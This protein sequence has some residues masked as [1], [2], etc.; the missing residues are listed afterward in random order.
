MPLFGLNFAS[1]K[2]KMET[3]AI[4]WEPIIKTYGIE[5]RTGL[6]LV[7]IPLQIENPDLE[8]LCYLEAAKECDN[9]VII[10][11]PPSPDGGVHLHLLFDGAP[12]PKTDGLE[13]PSRMQVEVPVEL[14]YFHGPHYGDRYGIA[15]AAL[16]ALT[17][18]NIPLKAMACS[19]ASVYIVVSEGDAQRGGK[20]LLGAFA[21]PSTKNGS[22]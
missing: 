7:T 8:P 18:A 19:G 3:I 21:V 5:V 6:S 14:V 1:G 15:N 2:S 20:A 13:F 4:Y 17:D 10:F 22:D 9:V 16:G 12:P 11:A